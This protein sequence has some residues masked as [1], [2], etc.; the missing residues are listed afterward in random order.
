MHNDISKLCI[1]VILC[2]STV[3]FQLKIFCNH[4]TYPSIS[5]IYLFLH[6]G[7]L[8]ESHCY[9]QLGNV[10]PYISQLPHNDHDRNRHTRH[11]PHRDERTKIPPPIPRQ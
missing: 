9:H 2:C 10:Q 11:A 4:T 8:V 6:L 3:C 5:S 7:P 1:G